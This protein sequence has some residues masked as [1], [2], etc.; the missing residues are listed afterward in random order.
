[1][2]STDPVSSITNCYRLIVSQTDTASSSRNAQ[3]SELDLVL[4]YNG[5]Q[6]LYWPCAIKN[7]P[8]P[9]YTVSVPP[10][11]SRCCYKKVKLPD[12]APTHHICQFWG[13]T[14]LFWPVN[15]APK[16]AKGA[17]AWKSTPPPVVVVVTNMS[18][19]C[20]LYGLVCHWARNWLIANR[21]S[22]DVLHSQAV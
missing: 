5:I 21:P 2:P 14:T 20:S 16:R 11:T 22:V 15:G 7:F 9:P 12:S 10:S 19:E 3:L 18:Y 13:T 8:V 6:V 17:S 1:M 4:I